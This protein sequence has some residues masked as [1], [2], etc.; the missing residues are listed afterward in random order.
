MV[1]CF[2]PTFASDS[3]AAA[4]FN[5][6]YADGKAAVYTDFAK[7]FGKEK[8]DVVYVCLPPFAHSNEVALAAKRDVHVFIEKPIAL[9]RKT[10]FTVM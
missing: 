7:M 9:D 3:S 4:A 6:R 10:A 8:L 2:A 1:K 5:E